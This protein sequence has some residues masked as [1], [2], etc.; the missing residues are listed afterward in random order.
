MGMTAAAENWVQLYVRAWTS[1]APDDIRATFTDDAVYKAR[2]DDP[3]P[4]IGIE[5]IV[6][7]WQGNV[8][9]PGTWSFEH[10]VIGVDG[11]LIFVQGTTQY[12]GD[13]HPIYF[14]LWVVRLAPDGRASAFTEW[15]MEPRTAPSA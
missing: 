11:D 6:A 8:D 1:N 14:N 2:P 12:P 10:E 3:E 15:F 9:P 13:E 4:L 5:Q 7:D